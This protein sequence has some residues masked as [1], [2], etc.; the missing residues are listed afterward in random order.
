MVTS[1]K[2]AAHDCTMTVYICATHNVCVLHGSTVM[3]VCDLERGYCLHRH[4]WR[5]IPSLQAV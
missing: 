2:M 1:S 5:Y 4:K 3:E